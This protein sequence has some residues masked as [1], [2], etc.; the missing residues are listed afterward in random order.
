VNAYRGAMHD[1]EIAEFSLLLEYVSEIPG[2]E[3]IRFTTSHPKEFTQS[4][5]M[6][7]AKFRNWSVI[8]I[9]GSMRF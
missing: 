2:I 4:L 5:M 6:S 3:R 8:C 9:C 7:T 1:G